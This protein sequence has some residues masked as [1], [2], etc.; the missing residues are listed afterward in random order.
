MPRPRPR[1]RDL[2]PRRASD[3]N[4]RRLSCGAPPDRPRA[5]RGAPRVRGRRPRPYASRKGRVRVRSL[6]PG[7]GHPTPRSPARV[8][9]DGGHSLR[10]RR[11]DRLMAKRRVFEI[12]QERGMTSKEVIALLSGGGIPV[13]AAQ[14]TV[15]DRHVNRILGP[16]PP[17]PEPE[18]EPEP[19]PE[20]EPEPEV[21]PTPEA[22]AGGRADPRAAGRAHRGARRGSG[23]RGAAP[24]AEARADPRSQDPDVAPGPRAGRASAG[25]RAARP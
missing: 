15:E 20:P 3:S 5:P 1:A 7:P 6:L 14:S 9:P 16:P 21:E 4:L 11:I 8:P 2:R 10:P 24:G 19:T 17:P 25:P 13:R 12:A 22:R 18:P 23:A